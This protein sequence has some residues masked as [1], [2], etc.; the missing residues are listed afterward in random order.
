MDY[1]CFIRN[2]QPYLNTLQGHRIVYY[3]C[4]QNNHRECIPQILYS[5]TRIIICLVELIFGICSIYYFWL[6]IISSKTCNVTFKIKCMAFFFGILASGNSFLWNL[7]LNSCNNFVIT[8]NLMY[9]T[10]F[11]VTNEENYR[12]RKKSTLKKIMYWTYTILILF[13]NIF[14]LYATN[15]KP[16]FILINYFINISFFGSIFYEMN[17]IV[18]IGLLFMLKMKRSIIGIISS[19]A[20][21][22]FLYNIKMARKKYGFL[23]DSFRAIEGY[24]SLI[25]PFCFVLIVPIF[26][27]FVAISLDFIWSVYTHE[28]FLLVF[29]LYIYGIPYTVFA[30]HVIIKCEKLKNVVSTY[31]V[32]DSLPQ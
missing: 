8:S 13:G 17:E 11:R 31:V 24:M 21:L 26:I 1:I 4:F 32:I 23:I 18:N 27:L 6:D 5:K 2:F 12:Y 16:I 19:P 28:E 10:F 15:G 9:K 14:V 7:K 22:D 30:R 25:V 20:G 3:K 29:F